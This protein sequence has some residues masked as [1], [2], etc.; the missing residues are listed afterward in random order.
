MKT[1]RSLTSVTIALNSKR[2]Q[3]SHPTR[4]TTNLPYTQWM[5]VRIIKAQRINIGN[6]RISKITR[7]I[8]KYPL[9]NQNIRLNQ[10][11]VQNLKKE[12]KILMRMT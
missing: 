6:P 10:E 5:K 9:Q 11:I 12:V 8:T 7:G 3:W 2:E 1:H 4:I